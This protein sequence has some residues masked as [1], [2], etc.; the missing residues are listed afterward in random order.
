MFLLLFL[1]TQLSIVRHFS[2]MNLNKQVLLHMKQF[3]TYSFKF[4]DGYKV[5]K[6]H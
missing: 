2:H 3:P 1:F 6:K 4:E 5:V